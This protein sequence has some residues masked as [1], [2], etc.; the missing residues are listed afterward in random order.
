VFVVGG[1]KNGHAIHRA[2]SM[3][4]RD[5]RRRW[6]NG[7]SLLEFEDGPIQLVKNSD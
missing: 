7:Q 6:R 5:S 2:A 3:C 1:A 4:I